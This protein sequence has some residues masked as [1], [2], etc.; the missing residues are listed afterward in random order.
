MPAESKQISVSEL[1]G[2]VSANSDLRVV[3]NRNRYLTTA[4]VAQNSYFRMVVPRISPHALLDC[5]HMRMRLQFATTSTD[6]DICVDSNFFYPFQRVRI[7]SGSTVLL[8]INNA[9]LLMTSLWNI[10]QNSSISAYEQSLVGDGDLATR[11][12]WADGSREYLIPIFPDNTVLRG[13]WL[14]DVNNSA[15]LILEFWTLPAA[16]LLYSPAVD[17]AATYTISS[18]IILSS[19][20]ESR[21]GF[22]LPTT[23]DGVH[24]ER[25]FRAV[26]YHRRKFGTSQTVEARP[27]HWMGFWRWFV[28]RTRKQASEPK[29]KWQWQT[30]SRCNPRIYLWINSAGTKP[31]LRSLNF[32]T[33]WLTCTQKRNRASGWMH[34]LQHSLFYCCSC[35]GCANSIRRFLDKWFENKQSEQ[36]PRVATAVLLLR[37][38]FNVSTHLQSDVVIYRDSSTRTISKSS[39]KKRK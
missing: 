7:L 30:H 6:A 10:E 9:N 33:S 38:Q 18:A 8:D 12:A 28:H 5:R 11:Q 3:H 15:D 21:V 14:F 36:R 2:R 31:F 32:S 27:P 26:C 16:T 19:F 4:S 34:C 37:L 23:P 29:T 1:V 35:F 13:D 24:G 20:I 17:T 39:C 22:L 25:L